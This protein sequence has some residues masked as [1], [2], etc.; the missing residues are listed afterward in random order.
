MIHIVSMQKEGEKDAEV[1]SKVHHLAIQ[2]QKATRQ[3][4]TQNKERPTH[5]KFK[6]QIQI[7][8]K[9]TRGS[10]RCE[11]DRTAITKSLSI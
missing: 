9:R 2:K 10:K 8:R 3:T 5:S 4:N 11:K 6:F 7:A 1:L